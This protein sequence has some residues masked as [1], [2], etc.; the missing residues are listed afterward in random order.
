MSGSIEV[1]TIDPNQCDT[2]RLAMPATSGIIVKADALGREALRRAVKAAAPKMRVSIVADGANALALLQRQPVDLALI[3]LDLPD[4]DGLELMASVVV[5]HLARRVLAIA[6]RRDQCS[7]Y[8]CRNAGIDGMIDAR[9]DGEKAV[10]AAIRGVLAGRKHFP[11]ECLVVP[12]GEVDIFKN[13]TPRELEVFAVIGA[14][15]DEPNSSVRLNVSAS[16]VHGYSDRIRWKLAARNRSEIITKALH[17]GMVRF[18]PLGKLFP[19]IVCARLKE[20]LGAVPKQV[21]QHGPA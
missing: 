18:T 11:R 7:E 10:A 20:R 2:N 1:C 8:F 16:T 14:G 3:G 13:F 9:F 12:Q 4:I 19:G 21:P 17:Y 15:G 6:E 5:E